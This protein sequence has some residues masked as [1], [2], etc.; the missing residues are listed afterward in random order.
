MN[1]HSD[2]FAGIYGLEERIRG[3][4]GKNTSNR[5]FRW[6]NA[7]LFFFPKSIRRCNII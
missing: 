6:K 2:Y 5:V 7:L 1:V 4:E 3:P